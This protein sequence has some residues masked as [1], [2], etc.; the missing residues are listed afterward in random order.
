MLVIGVLV[1]MF[2]VMNRKDKKESS[3]SSSSVSEIEE[4]TAEIIET[5]TEAEIP[6]TTAEITAEITTT[7]VATTTEQPE[8]DS[9]TLTSYP[10]SNLSKY[11][12]YIK[13]AESNSD[14]GLANYF[15]LLDIN[16]DDIPELFLTDVNGR[17]YAI[18]AAVGNDYV[19]LQRVGGTGR[20]WI[21]LYND[22]TISHG[23]SFGNDGGY[24]DYEY[25]GGNEL[26]EIKS[27]SLAEYNDIPTSHGGE[28]N[29]S[30]SSLDDYITKPTENN[31]N[32][33]T[34]YD[35]SAAT[36]DFQF[37]ADQFGYGGTI[38]TQDDPLNLRAAPLSNAEVIIKMPK[39]SNIFIFGYNNDWYYVSYTENG[40][41][42]YGYASKQFI[43][44]SGI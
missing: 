10:E 30:V 12:Q 16:A 23:S 35:T 37:N 9:K 32:N 29:I 13:A 7:I 3:K 22:G 14:W 27:Y 1:G 43:E 34:V 25:S 40:V 8:K 2:F 41:T 28:A 4:T 17:I 24:T 18:Y 19:E 26:K 11:P 38:I 31:A 36:A 33:Y 21:T 20:D 15:A 42:Y 5:T 39:G 44:A 6:T